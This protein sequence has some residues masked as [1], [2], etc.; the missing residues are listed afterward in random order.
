MTKIENRKERFQYKGTLE[1][2]QLK[3]KDGSLQSNTENV[4]SPYQ[5]TSLTQYQNSLYK[6]ALYGFGGLTEEQK[7]TICEKK[8]KRI[9]RVYY[10]GQ[11]AINLYKQ[12][13]TNAY[14][15]ALLSQLFPN[16]PITQ[17]FINNSE[18]DEKFTNTLTFK[19]LGIT[20]EKIIS[21][22]IEN[23]VLS[24]NFY[25]QK[26][27]PNQLPRLRNASKEKNM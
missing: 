27:D 7:T 15:N 24:K 16:H 6:R 25:S 26:K 2:Y 11:V 17:F 19:Q 3:L 12:K 23:G 4:L 8:K 13:I 9:S 20:K 22:F 21:I 14:S 1:E 18:T 10:K 5:S